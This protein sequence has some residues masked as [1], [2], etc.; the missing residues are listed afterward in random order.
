MACKLVEELFAQG[1]TQ[2]KNDY[3]LFYKKSDDRIC[4]ATVYVDDVI[5]T[6]SDDI[7]IKDLKTHLNVLFGI[8]DLGICIISW[9]LK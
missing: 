1:F 3:S 5:I 7:A 4:I 8:K 2:S 9:I 6:G